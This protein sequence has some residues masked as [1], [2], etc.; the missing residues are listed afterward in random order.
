MDLCPTALSCLQ[1]QG[2]LRT[3]ARVHTH[4]YTHHTHEQSLLRRASD[5]VRSC[6]PSELDFLLKTEGVGARSTPASDLTVMKTCF[7]PLI[8]HTSRV[9]SPVLSLR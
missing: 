8:F 9:F 2:A 6:I 3:C 7:F 5:L 4:V 1:G